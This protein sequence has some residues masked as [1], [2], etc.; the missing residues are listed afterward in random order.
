MRGAESGAAESLI[1]EAPPSEEERFERRQKHVSIL[2]RLEDWLQRDVAVAHPTAMRNLLAPLPEP[3]REQAAQVVSTYRIKHREALLTEAEIRGAVEDSGDPVTEGTMGAHVFRARTGH[4]PTGE[5]RFRRVESYFIVSAA[6]SEDYREFYA[7]GIT[8]DAGE[9]AQKRR[10]R[11]DQ[12]G[13][14]YHTRVQLDAPQAV[15]TESYVRI[16]LLGGLPSVLLIKG[17]VSGKEQ[18]RVVQHERQHHINHEFL[19]LFERAERRRVD[20]N[21]QRQEARIK[22]EVLAYLRDGSSGKMLRQCLLD[23]LYDHLFESPDAERERQ[24]RKTV[25]DTSVAVGML[26]KDFESPDARAV[27]VYHLFDIPLADIPHRL[28]EITRMLR[29]RVLALDAI[30]KNGVLPYPKGASFYVSP[31]QDRRNMSELTR[32]YTELTAA[33]APEKQKEIFQSDHEAFARLLKKFRAV[34]ERYDRAFAATHP[35]GVGISIGFISQY[36]GERP[37][38]QAPSEAVEREARR[39]IDGLMAAIKKFPQLF[40]DEI[41]SDPSRSNVHPRTRELH[42][43]LTQ[44]LQRDG[45]LDARMGNAYAMPDRTRLDLELN[46]QSAVDPKTRVLFEICLFARPNP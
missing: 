2:L 12:H 44:A 28:R 6:L 21:V 43:M 46:W 35:N 19:S 42:R 22:D 29:E 25:K 9:E 27:L 8:S 1:F 39:I 40:L 14:T 17:S 24:L 13:G 34:R 15:R 31:G 20:P 3:I 23:P 4:L 45:A 38:L 30:C 11:L 37:G 41:V 33:D 36:Q 16:E 32:A 5:V 7:P 26:G 10:V 18:E